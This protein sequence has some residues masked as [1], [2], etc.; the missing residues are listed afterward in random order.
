MRTADLEPRAHLWRSAALCLVRAIGSTQ[1]S[2][3]VE[4][5]CAVLGA[6]TIAG[7]G[8]LTSFHTAETLPCGDWQVQAALG[9]GS[10][11]DEPFDTRT[12][13][14]HAELSA[15]VGLTDD[16]ELGAKLYTLGAE[17]S[18]RHRLRR[19]AGARG[20]SLAAHTSFGGVRSR[21]EGSLPEM[22]LVQARLGGL[23]TWRSGPHLAWTLGAIGTGSL[24]VP[25]GGGHATGT[26]LGGVANLDWRFAARWHLLPELSLHRSLTGEVPVDGAVAMAGLAVAWDL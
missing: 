19:P 3:G 2:A 16:T 1:V 23:A 13:A 20:L 22:I 9:A 17:L 4:R 11:R 24:F 15:R 25:A 7:C 6:L 26:L 21:G 14:A 12:P 18:A 10:Y 8:S 5:T